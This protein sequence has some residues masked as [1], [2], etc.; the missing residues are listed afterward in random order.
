MVLAKW[1]LRLGG[2]IYVRHEQ[3]VPGNPDNPETPLYLF[4]CAEH[5]IVD[6][7][8][9][10]GYERRLDCSLCTLHQYPDTGMR[11]VQPNEPLVA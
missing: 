3:L 4:Y 2:R 7:D 6:I 11:I 5:D 9:E 10:H 1:W 8:Y